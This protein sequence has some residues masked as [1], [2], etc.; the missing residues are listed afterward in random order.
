MH[1][2][3]FYHDGWCHHLFCLNSS[4]TDAALD[5]LAFRFTED[6]F[7]GSYIYHGRNLFAAHGSLVALRREYLCD[8][9]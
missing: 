9:F 2:S 5:D 1:I 8:K 4:Q 7:C 3:R 6:A